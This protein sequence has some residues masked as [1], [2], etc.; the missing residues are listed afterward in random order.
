[1]T[2]PSDL[3]HPVLGQ[4][5]DVPE[6]RAFRSRVSLGE[7][8]FVLVVMNDPNAVLNSLMLAEICVFGTGAVEVS[9]D[10]PDD[11]FSGYGVLVSLNSDLAVEALSLIHI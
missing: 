5:R 7:H 8:L 9:F 3:F 2:T 6:E 1:M 4:L 10:A 11:F